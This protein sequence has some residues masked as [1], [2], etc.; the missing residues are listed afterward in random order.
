MHLL[1]SPLPPSIV[2]GTALDAVP[3]GYLIA[4]CIM[5]LFAVGYMAIS[6]HVQRKQS[7]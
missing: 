7:W 2:L 4:G 3:G 1:H 5:A 6:R